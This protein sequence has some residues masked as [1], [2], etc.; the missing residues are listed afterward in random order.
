VIGNDLISWIRTARALILAVARAAR[1]LGKVCAPTQDGPFSMRQSDLDSP[2][3]FLRIGWHYKKNV[4][5]GRRTCDSV[6]GRS[7]EGVCIHIET[8]AIRGDQPKSL[9]SR[10]IVSFRDVDGGVVPVVVEI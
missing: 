2:L 8:T 5:S 3:A 4:V 7:R 6:Q 9:F 1:S 10:V